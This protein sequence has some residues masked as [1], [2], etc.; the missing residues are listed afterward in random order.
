MIG[1]GKDSNFY[2]GAKEDSLKFNNTELIE[3]Q[4]LDKYA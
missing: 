2:R 4:I 3:F 1:T